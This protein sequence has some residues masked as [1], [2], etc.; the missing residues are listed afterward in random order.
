MNKWGRVVGPTPHVDVSPTTKLALVL[1]FSDIGVSPT[2]T[3]VQHFNEIYVR[4]KGRAVF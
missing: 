4:R 1:L 3:I 2:P